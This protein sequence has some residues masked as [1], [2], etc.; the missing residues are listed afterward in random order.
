MTCVASHRLKPPAS[1]CETIE[2]RHSDCVLLLPPGKLIQYEEM[3]RTSDSD[4]ASFSTILP[5]PMSTTMLLSILSTSLSTSR[6]A[7]CSLCFPLIFSLSF[8]LASFSKGI[9]S[10]IAT[11]LASL[12]LTQFTVY[13]TLNSPYL[14]I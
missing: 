3:T 12:R 14:K 11:G 1:Q 7:C 10:R 6:F 5:S 13:F 9:N 4:S 8:F 2:T